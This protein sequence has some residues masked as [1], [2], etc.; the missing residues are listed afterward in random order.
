VTK[1]LGVIHRWFPQR[2]FGFVRD[3]ISDY[4]GRVVATGH[5]PDHYVSAD[6]MRRS[7]IEPASIKECAAVRFV[8][9]PSRR[10]TG[11]TVA[12][13]IELVAATDVEAAA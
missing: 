10:M 11:K 12:I 4:R 2:N 3:A 8:A 5:G 1:Q 9:E 6:I 7:G 13:D